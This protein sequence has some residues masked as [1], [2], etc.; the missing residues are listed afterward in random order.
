M[1]PRNQRQED[2]SRAYVRAVAARAGVSCSDFIND[3]GID[4]C[5]RDVEEVGRRFSDSGDQIDVQV[6]STGRAIVT[7]M[8]VIYD[9]ECRTYDLLR[10]AHPRCARVL[11]LVLLPPDE[12]LWL[13]QTSE[14]LVL[15][16]CGFWLSLRGAPSVDSETTTRIAIP[17]ANVFSPEVVRSMMQ[18]VNRGE[19]P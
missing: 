15:R 11:V 13:S 2:F 10:H 19:W 4:M 17:R 16:R 9:L 6:K 7:D 18:L 8:E 3:F 14:E 5:L 12:D 1:L